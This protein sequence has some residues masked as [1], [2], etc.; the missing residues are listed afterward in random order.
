M[1]PAVILEKA[2]LIL[3]PRQRYFYNETIW[4]DNFCHK[5]IPVVEDIK[6]L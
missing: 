3:H 1:S 5:R 4:K 6:D 2:I